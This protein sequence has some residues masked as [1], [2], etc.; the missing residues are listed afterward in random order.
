[1][2]FVSLTSRGYPVG[3]V[4]LHDT[5][6]SY[7][8]SMNNAPVAEGQQVRGSEMHQVESVKD[9]KRIVRVGGQMSLGQVAQVTS[10]TFRGGHLSVFPISPESLG[11]R[12]GLMAK[13]YEEQVFHLLEI[14]YVPGVP[15]TTAGS[16]GMWFNNDIAVPTWVLGEDSVAHG[17]THD[18][19][20]QTPVWESATISVKPED[21]LKRY[22]NEE[23]GDFR[24][25]VQ[26]LVHII[27]TSTLPAGPYGS[28][29]LKYDCSFSSPELDYEV[30]DVETGELVLTWTAFVCATDDPIIFDSRAPAATLATWG[31][32]GFSVVPEQL[33]YGACTLGPVSG[34]P[35]GWRTT[36]AV[37]NHLFSVGMVFWFRTR[38]VNIAGSDQVVL[39]VYSNLASAEDDTRAVAGVGEASE[40][41]LV[42]DAA[43]TATDVMRFT[44]RVWQLSDD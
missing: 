6:S 40:G 25:E 5:L 29:F 18:S 14:I 16:L 9:G 42:Y 10:S 35:P 27:A 12:L 17:A 44:V 4:R 22:F 34:F 26:G 20:I 32:A 43:G 28:L 37:E 30:Q 7:K 8:S 38:I 23:A 13:D 24:L 21:T 2:S 36:N 31:A 15:T 33:Y 3:R 11:G 41:Q 19:F 1:M 39:M